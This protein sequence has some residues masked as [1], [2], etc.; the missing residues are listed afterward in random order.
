[1][2]SKIINLKLLIGLGAHIGHARIDWNT[3]TDAYLA[4]MTNNK[5]LIFNINKTLYLFKRS[6]TFLR[7]IG[8]NGGKFVVYFPGEDPFYKSMM[9]ASLDR[10]GLLPTKYPFIHSFVKPGFFSNWRTNYKQFV[11]QFYKA[12]F[13]NPYFF[14]ALSSQIFHGKLDNSTLDHNGSSFNTYLDRLNNLVVLKKTKKGHYQRV[15]K[16]LKLHR[17][18]KRTH[19]RSY[20]DPYL[21]KKSE[22]SLS[23]LPLAIDYHN[24]SS[25]SFYPVYVDLDYLFI[26]MSNMYI[27]SFVSYKVSTGISIDIYY[28]KYNKK[29]INS[30]YNY[31]KTLTADKWYLSLIKFESSTLRQ[32]FILN[33]Y[34]DSSTFPSIYKYI[35][36]LHVKLINVTRSLDSLCKN[37]RKTYLPFLKVKVYINKLIHTYKAEHVIQRWL[38]LLSKI[39]NL[40]DGERRRLTRNVGV[41]R[42]KFSCNDLAKPRVWS[43]NDYPMFHHMM[44]QFKNSSM[45]KLHPKYSPLKINSYLSS[46]YNKVQQKRAWKSFEAQMRTV[47][48]DGFK[49]LY[50]N[51]YNL[52]VNIAMYKRKYGSMRDALSPKELLLFRRFIRF[53]IIFRYLKRLM[54][55]PSAVILLNSDVHESQYSDF[56]NL[57]TAVVGMLDS[58][59]SFRGLSYFIPTNDDSI[60]LF[61]YYIKMLSYSYT[62]G[63][64]ARFLDLVVPKFMNNVSRDTTYTSI[65]FSGGSQYRDLKV[66]SQLV[67]TPNP[68]RESV[69]L[70]STASVATDYVHLVKM[71]LRKKEKQKARDE[72][73]KWKDRMRLL[74]YQKYSADKTKKNSGTKLFS[75]KTYKSGQP[76]VMLD[77]SITHYLSRK[78]TFTTSEKKVS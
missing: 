39:K 74:R 70:L 63:H 31:K 23:T 67:N 61:L 33:N 11:K 28:L 75:N 30:S 50:Y 65:R 51:I 35:A 10:E 43:S 58:N 25:N 15:I 5:Y 57:N 29:L 42:S 45:K 12:I 3:N 34:H 56:Q 26:C 72:Y 13:W 18:V 6:L 48:N 64:K 20:S 21:F 37:S 49:M 62:L 40:S 44:K 24:S 27:T 52:L 14:S 73:Y 47:K 8:Y 1:M 66:H 41:L 32:S 69:N 2:I 71:S 36:P 54:K 7:L 46:Y 22:T 9:E 55:I 38:N 68:Q 16:D 78:N 17:K 59:I 77:R 76:K 4:G 19:F 60:V 53:T